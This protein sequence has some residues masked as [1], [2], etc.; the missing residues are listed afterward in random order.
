MTAIYLPRGN[1]LELLLESGLLK[2]HFALTLQDMKR[3]EFCG[4]RSVFGQYMTE[5]CHKMWIWTGKPDTSGEKC[6]KFDRGV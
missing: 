1:V 2:P 6:V 5:V 4:P 3:T